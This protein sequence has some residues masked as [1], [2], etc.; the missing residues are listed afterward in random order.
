MQQSHFFDIFVVYKVDVAYESIQNKANTSAPLNFHNTDSKSRIMIIIHSPC[1]VRFMVTNTAHRQFKQSL[2][3]WLLSE[4]TLQQD[5]LFPEVAE[6][7][8]VNSWIKCYYFGQNS[9]FW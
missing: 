3:L 2:Q 5:K 1:T 8:C 4:K 7:H 6:R 9:R